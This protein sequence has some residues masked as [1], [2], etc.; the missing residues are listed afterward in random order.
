[1]ICVWGIHESN[2]IDKIAKLTLNRFTSSSELKLF[3]HF[4]T[5]KNNNIALTKSSQNFPCF[6]KMSKHLSK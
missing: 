1:M 3:N 4:F 5:D 2:E 6:N